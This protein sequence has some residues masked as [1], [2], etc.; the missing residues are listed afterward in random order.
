MAKVQIFLL[1]YC[2]LGEF[3]KFRFVNAGVGHALMI[4]LEEHSLIV[5]A[6]DGAEIKPV[7]VR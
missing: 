3:V 6:A 5:V 7:K 2:F 4:W 1:H